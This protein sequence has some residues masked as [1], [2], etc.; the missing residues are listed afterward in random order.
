MGGRGSFINVFSGDFAFKEGGQTYFSIGSIGDNIKVLERP[1]TSVKAPEYSHT[2]NR[3]YV[4]MQKGELKHIAF[5]NESHELIKSIDFMH[6]HNGIQ[7]HVHFDILH[8]GNVSLPSL[9]D[10]SIIRQVDNWI[11]SHKK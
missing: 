2:K 7:P 9:E 8:Q 3:V 4:I 6:Q 5:Y 11:S 1:G 10:Q